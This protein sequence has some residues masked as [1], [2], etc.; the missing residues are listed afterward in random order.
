MSRIERILGIFEFCTRILYITGAVAV[1]ALFLLMFGDVSGRFL[2]NSPIRGTAEVSEYL[3]VAIAFLSLG[4]AQLEGTHIS[5]ET[6]V[7]LLPRKLRACVDLFLL[8]LAIGF[9]VI[10]TIQIS[11]RTYLDW[12]DNILLSATAVRLPVWWLSIIGAT[13]CALLVISFVVQLIRK[14]IHLG[15]D[16]DR[17]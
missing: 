17:K 7:A 5:V 9:F 14:I 13:G 8:L 2:F 3:I 15:Q 1:C 10:M 6:L 4:Y 16:T 11:E 12:K